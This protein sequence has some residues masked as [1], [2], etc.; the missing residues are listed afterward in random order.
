MYNGIGLQTPRGSGTNGY[1]QTNKFFVKPKNHKVDTKEFEAGQG[2]AGVK[3]ANK[4]ILEHD[5]KRQIQLKLVLLEETLIDQGYTDDEIASKLADAQKALEAEESTTGSGTK[6]E[7]RVSDTHTHQIAARKERQLETLRAALGI[8]RDETLEQE[9]KDQKQ[10]DTIDSGTEHSDDEQLGENQKTVAIPAEQGKNEHQGADQ[11]REKSSREE[12]MERVLKTEKEDMKEKPEK[13]DTK[14]VNR[15]EKRNNGRKD[16]NDGL[17]PKNSRKERYDD[18]DDSDTDSGN[19]HRKMAKEKYG[20][21]TKRHDSEDSDISGSK[22]SKMHFVKYK[23][24]K[25]ES[26]SSDADSDGL[27]LKERGKYAKTSLKH[28]S[29]SEKETLSKGQVEKHRNKRR[30]H[31]SEDESDSD[32]GMK[33]RRKQVVKH[34]KQSRRHDSDNSDTDGGMNERSGGKY[35]ANNELSPDRRKSAKAQMEMS[36]GEKR[37]HDTQE[38]DSSAGRMNTKKNM[39]KRQK[40][41]RER[42]LSTDDSVSSTDAS[43]YSSDS[44]SSSSSD[45]DSGS[46]SDYSNEKSAGKIVGN[47]KRKSDKVDNENYRGAK[48]QHGLT[49][50][51]DDRG[52]ER[53]DV[54]YDDGNR[55]DQKRSHVDSRRDFRDEVFGNQETKGKGKLEDGDRR[56]LLG[57]RSR[58]SDVGE[59]ERKHRENRNVIYPS[60]RDYRNNDDRRNDEFLSFK[61]SGEKLSTQSRYDDDMG[62]RS[63]G[64]EMEK[65]F[66]RSRYDDDIGSR[67]RGTEMEK[68]SKRSRYDD[69][70][71][72]RSR[73]TEMEKDSKRS[74]YD[75]DIGGR[76]RGTEMEKDSKRSRYDDDIG[77]RRRGTEMEKDSKR[78]RYDD[79][80][81]GRSRGTEMEK[82][83]R[84]SR[85]DDSYSRQSRSESHRSNADR[86]R[87]G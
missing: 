27:E 14:E 64:T 29:G 87:R 63:R 32:I 2:T 50:G 21:D 56:D 68:D 60:S 20:K 16:E 34:G 24:K 62:G 82:D 77:G 23:S 13:E 54:R 57:S 9:P 15:H 37:Q 12:R 7:K 47:E 17:K 39:P 76:R 40:T 31:D 28:D 53:G 10:D 43:V 8:A 18:D 81:G 58:N 79:D 85:Y 4:E 25:H 41:R 1:I 35:S 67:G 66:K 38:N 26:D 45:S 61:K 36:R 19:Y 72:G 46:S 3:K 44:D 86:C 42:E 69:D 65:D 59:R 30:R 6:I 48:N 22:K 71:G 75:D 70:I 78:S 55:G 73:G 80:I 84:R 51:R 49:T 33:N 83:S 74:R 5:R 52:K 11:G